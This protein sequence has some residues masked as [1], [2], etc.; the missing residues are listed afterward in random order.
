MNV[1]SQPTA[2]V[3]RK[4][5]P[6]E[7]LALLGRGGMGV[8]YVAEDT[9]LR[10]RVALKLLPQEMSDRPERLKRFRREAK[11]V[12]A[13]SHPNIVTLHSVEDAEGFHFLTMEL[14]EGETLAEAIP[15][16]GFSLERAVDVAHALA[17]ALSAAHD[18]GVLHRDLKPSNVMVSPNGWVKV[19]D[20]GLAK[21]RPE[22]ELTWIGGDGT[23]LLQTQE[24][25][26][27]GTPSY[28]SPEQLRG[29]TADERSDIFSLG[30]VFYEMLAGR[31][32]FSG[33]TSAERI[34]SVL[35]DA[36]RPLPELRPEIPSS[37]VRVVERCLQ[38]EPDKR[39]QSALAL[40]E[41][42]ANLKREL[43]ISKLIES[44]AISA[45][46]RAKASRLSPRSR[47]SATS[48]S[49]SSAR[50]G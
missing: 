44:G 39:Y 38:K 47:R 26:V 28:M 30:L 48:P 24:G 43:E 7:I 23:S 31:L 42:L 27:L 32:P 6:Y 8:V 19:L 49:W 34:A 36:P 20:F 46:R 15:Q 2:L 16:Q 21:L 11:T 41:D 1:E 17:S 37:V 3:G 45:T 50:C 29:Q 12:A 10:R 18:R 5:G 33:E 25:K 40:R 14:I 9:R 22:D 4:L 13:L 35:R